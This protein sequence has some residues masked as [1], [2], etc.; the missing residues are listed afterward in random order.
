MHGMLALHEASCFPQ[1]IDFTTYRYIV[2]FFV[3]IGLFTVSPIYT[4]KYITVITYNVI[5]TGVLLSTVCNII[6]HYEQQGSE[7]DYC[8]FFE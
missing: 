7:D 8:W 4:V 5:H 2:C 6:S 1:D 3:Y